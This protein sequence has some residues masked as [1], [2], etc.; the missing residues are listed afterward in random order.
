MKIQPVFDKES[1]LFVWEIS[2]ISLPMDIDNK[3]SNIEWISYY[4]NIEENSARRYI[5]NDIGIGN[6]TDTALLEIKNHLVND[7]F[8]ENIHQAWPDD[9]LK[10][11]DIPKNTHSIIKD[12]PNT[13]MGEHW[14]NF[15]IYGVFIFNLKDNPNARTAYYDFK[16]E[17]LLYEGPTK[18]GTGIFHLNSAACLHSGYNKGNEDRIISM[19]VLSVKN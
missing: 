17:T 3:L 4:A 6:Y 7:I 5:G 16:T 1:Q 14:D 15:L 10:N 13:D 2:D 12:I 11:Y 19:T 8:Y 18:K 9:Y